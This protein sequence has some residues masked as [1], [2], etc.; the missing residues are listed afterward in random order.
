MQMST[1]QFPDDFRW[2][3]ATAAFQIEGAT[4]KDGRGE[5]IWDRFCAIPGAIADSSDG[6]VACD[7]YH[8]WQADIAMMRELGLNS[9]RF[10]IAWP[11]IFPEG[12]GKVNQA[13]LDFYSRLVDGLLEAGIT[14]FATLYHWDLPQALQERGGWAVRDIVS[15]FASYADT[16]ARALG[17]R[18]RH[19]ITHNEPAVVAFHGYKTGE[20]APGI[21]NPRMAYQVMHH[22]LLSHGYAMDAIRAAAPAAQAGITLNLF[23]VHPASDSEQDIQAAVVRD[24]TDNRIFLDPIFHARYPEDIMR[25]LGPLTPTIQEG[26]FEKIATQI[27]FLGINYYHRV[28]VK[29][30]PDD[31]LTPI[32][33]FPTG[34]EY[35]EMGWEVYP[36]GLREL[37]VRLNKEYKAPAYTTSPR[38]ARPSPTR[39]NPMA[40]Y[41]TPAA[42]PTSKAT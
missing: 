24:G 2:G 26:D 27:D 14:P 23:A 30:N 1:S 22:L 37:L 29:H 8:R 40:L 25:L 39:S 11:R 19:W 41:M 17:D 5:S 12:I 32:Q 13:G 21:H 20:H 10:S 18:V 28:V 3:A 36:D 38:T 31:V 7:H 16:M 35:T 33:V 42:L 15:I 6:S 4:H 9:Y 34:S